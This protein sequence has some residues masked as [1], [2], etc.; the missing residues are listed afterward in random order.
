[1]VLVEKSK[2]KKREEG[3]TIRLDRATLPDSV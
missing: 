1:M 3:F 2:P